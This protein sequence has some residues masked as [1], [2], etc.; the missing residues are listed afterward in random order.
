MRAHSPATTGGAAALERLHPA[1]FALVMATGIVSIAA[2]IQGLRLI[3]ITLLG[4]NVAAYTGLWVVMAARAK[5]YPRPFLA[6]ISDHTR[7]PGFFTWVAGTGVFGAQFVLIVRIPSL[8]LALWGLTL[9][10]WLLI[11]YSVFTALS[12]KESKPNLHDGINGGWLVAIVATQSVSVLS[13][14]VAVLIP[15]QQEEILLVALLTWLFGGMLYIWIISLIFYR[16]TFLKFTPGDLSPPYW[17][18][19]GAMAIST[20][21]GAL[22]IQSAPVDPLL[23]ELMPFLKGLTLLFWATGSW[24]IPLLLILGVWRYVIQRFPFEYDPL[25]WGMVF[26]I[27]MYTVCTDELASVMKLPFLR[28]IPDSFIYLSLLAWIATFVAWL[29]QALLPTCM[30]MVAARKRS[31]PEH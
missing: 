13:S 21:A 23:R 29:T 5:L 7:G 6:D 25:Y 28:P 31:R 1:Y 27:G 15:A 16:Y 24:W 2:Q 12:I 9:L 22:L 10:L 3:A 11:T 18:N 14:R 20:L 8:A 4:I 17:I 19:M 26:P 30:A